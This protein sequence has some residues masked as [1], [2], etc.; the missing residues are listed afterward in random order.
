MIDKGAQC[1]S[2]NSSH[3]WPKVLHWIQVRQIH[4]PLVWKGAFCSKLL[5][6]HSKQADFHTFYFLE[7]Q[8]DLKRQNPSVRKH[9]FRYFTSRSLPF[10]LRT[11]VPIYVMRFKLKELS[12]VMV[13]PWTYMGSQSDNPLLRK[14]P[15][16]AASPPVFY[17][18]KIS[19]SRPESLLLE[20]V[21]YI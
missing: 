16:S 9:G 2:T 5:N 20:P 11:N 18:Q 10:I 13:T 8:H 3:I 17:P 4:P 1:L 19:L 6:I 21:R 7:E 12:L 15:K 14:A